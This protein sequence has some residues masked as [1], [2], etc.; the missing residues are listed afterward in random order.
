MALQHGQERPAQPSWGYASAQA[1]TGSPGVDG[2]TCNP[3]PCPSSFPRA[4]VLLQPPSQSQR[5][6]PRR[7]SPVQVHCPIGSSCAGRLRGVPASSSAP[8]RPGRLTPN[9]GPG[10]LCPQGSQAW[11]RGWA[12]HKRPFF[13]LHFCPAPQFCLGSF[14]FHC[15]L[16]EHLLRAVGV[17][18]CFDFVPVGNSHPSGL[19]CQGRRSGGAL[20]SAPTSATSSGPACPPFPKPPRA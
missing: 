10:G 19:R 14:F 6:W 17:G 5:P 7:E 13:V 1:C 3:A 12:S 15:E 18:S 4:G 16:L 2:S 11:A 9:S 20:S 8:P